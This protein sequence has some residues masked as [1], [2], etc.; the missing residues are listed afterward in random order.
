MS[1]ANNTTFYRAI[2]RSENS[3]GGRVALY[4]EHFEP[5]WILSGNFKPPPREEVIFKLI[6]MTVFVVSKYLRRL[7]ANML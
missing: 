3:E 4:A 2:G 6:F 1:Q 5:K 7:C